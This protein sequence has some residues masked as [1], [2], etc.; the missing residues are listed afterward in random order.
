MRVDLTDSR[1]TKTVIEEPH[2]PGEEVQ[3]S[4][5]GYGS[6]VDFRI[7]YNGELVKQVHAKAHGNNNGDQGDQS[8][9]NGTGGGNGGGNAADN[10]SRSGTDW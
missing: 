7:F 10:I 6:E 5:E 8:D 4:A 9:Q 2:N 3:V 1:G